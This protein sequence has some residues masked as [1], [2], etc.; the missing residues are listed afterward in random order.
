MIYFETVKWKN[1]LSTGDIW[2]ELSLSTDNLTLINGENGAGKTTLLDAIAFALYNKP[3]RNINKPQLINS[4]N[5]KDLTV[6]LTFRIGKNQ[7]KI[8]RGIKPNI[9]EIWKNLIS[10][11]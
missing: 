3:Y 9:F 5:K 8:V 4:I 10:T 7:Y 6:E 11:Y 1:L 2:T